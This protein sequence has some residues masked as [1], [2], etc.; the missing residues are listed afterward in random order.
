MESNE[1]ETFWLF[2]LQFCQAYG[3]AYN[4]NFWFSL[5]CKNSYD[6]DYDYDFVTNENQP[7]TPKRYDEHP[8]RFYMGVLP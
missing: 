7:L 6:F 3:F 4:C 1:T 5:G 2:R 8:R